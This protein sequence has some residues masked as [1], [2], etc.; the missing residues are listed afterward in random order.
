MESASEVF[1]WYETVKLRI[2]MV[3]I[4]AHNIFC[5]P[6][7]Q[8]ENKRDFSLTGVIGRS[9]QASFTVT[10]LAM[11]VY[12]DKSKNINR[13]LEQINP[14]EASTDK[15]EDDLNYAKSYLKEVGELDEIN[16]M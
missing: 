11:L 8:I 10:N 14:F 7:S 12:I 2:P 9:Q 4:F 13:S 6:A 5:I 1:D 3:Y 15:L 16:V